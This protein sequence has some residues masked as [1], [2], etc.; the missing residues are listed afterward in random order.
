MQS[1]AFLFLENFVFQ[2][3]ILSFHLKKVILKLKLIN[4]NKKNIQGYFELIKIW[5]ANFR[6]ICYHSVAC[7]LPRTNNIK[8]L[9]SWEWHWSKLKD[10]CYSELRMSDD[11]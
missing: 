7:F 11:R 10:K 1:D 6:K 8:A 4:V 5:S 3:V 2:P 9:V